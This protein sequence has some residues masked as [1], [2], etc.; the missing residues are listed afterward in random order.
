M[1]EESRPHAWRG[2]P[3]WRHNAERHASVLRAVAKDKLAMRMDEHRLPG[4]R[5]CVSERRSI[6]RSDTRLHFEGG[7]P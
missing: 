1:N 7:A 5:H 4:L 2:G 6:A 3:F